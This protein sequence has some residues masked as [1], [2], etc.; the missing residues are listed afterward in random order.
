MLH[1]TFQLL[2]K[3]GDGRCFER[4]Y[5]KLARS[6]GGVR[7]YGRDT[8]IPLTA[9]LDNNG[10][11][12]ALWALRATAEDSGPIARE[13]ACD[14]AEHVLPIFERD[15]PDDKRPREGIEVARRYA[16]GEA[17]DEELAAAEDATWDAAWAAAGYAAGYATGAAARTADRYITLLAARA[18][19][20]VAEDTE[21]TWQKRRLR[22]KLA[23]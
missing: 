12:N 6:L 8:P 4:R 9:V 18:A 1:T 5:R 3:Y 2:R 7:A 16:R 21:S 11:D 17:T 20:D 13:L 14:Y 22:E 19:G 10:L 23:T 15:Y